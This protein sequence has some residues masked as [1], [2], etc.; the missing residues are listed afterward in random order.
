MRRA[1]EDLAVAVKVDQS[2]KTP[3]R[4]V[5]GDTV[6]AEQIPESDLDEVFLDEAE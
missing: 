4:Y 3:L 5:R 2:G 6:E 1:Q